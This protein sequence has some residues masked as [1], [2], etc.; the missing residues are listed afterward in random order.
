MADFPVVPGART[1]LLSGAGARRGGRT[2]RAGTEVSGAAGENR[3]A[4]EGQQEDCAVKG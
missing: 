3:E 2:G 1:S 4:D